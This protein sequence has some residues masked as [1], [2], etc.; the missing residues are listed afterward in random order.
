MDS[1]T[2]FLPTLSNLLDLLCVATVAVLCVGIG[3][4]VAPRTVPE[5]ALL[6]GWGLCCIVLTV[7]GCFSAVSLA[8]PT[9]VLAAAG[10]CGCWSLRDWRQDGLWRVAVSSA[11]IW[12][13]MLPV[14][15]SQVDTWLNLLPNAAYLVDH[16]MFPRSDRPPSYSFI[17]VAPYNTQFVAY[18]ASLLRGHLI[19]HGMGL[20]NILLQCA[21]SG[22]LARIVAGRGREIGWGAAA[23][24]L[25]LAMP[26]NPGFIPREFFS[27]Y[28]EAPIAVTAMTA[29]LLGAQ[30]TAEREDRG[31]RRDL[32]VALALIL[33]A[34]VNV[35][36]SAIGM[37]LGVLA[38]MAV[39]ALTEHER[40]HRLEQ[41]ILQA[42]PMLA[43]Y[44]IWRW[45][46][47]TSFAAGELKALP[48]AQW[49]IILIPRILEG[50]A[51]AISQKGVFFSAM[52]VV[53]AGAIFGRPRN[54]VT[55][56]AL[57]L[58][59]GTIL[60]DN[61]FI[62]FTYV[63]HFEPSWAVQAHSYFRYMAQLSLIVMLGLTL[64]A[65]PPAR[66]WFDSR[67]GRLRQALR[68]AAIT[69]ILAAPFAVIRYLRFDLEPPQP[70][71]SGMVAAIKPFL[72]SGEP[73][74]LVVTDDPDDIAGSYLRG[75]LLF[76]TPRADFPVVRTGS[77]GDAGTLAALRRDGIR[78]IL[79]ACSSQVSGIPGPPALAVLDA[80]ADGWRVAAALPYPSSWGKGHWAGLV[81]KASLCA[82][83]S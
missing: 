6:A 64:L 81:S 47:T 41:I 75:L 67:T 68:V 27:D 14:G 25:L 58:G 60:V 17:P 55:R 21:A 11:G 9:G 73:L 45:Y 46:A 37:A 52:A 57:G 79:V 19:G 71:L 66:R 3:R 50:V 32:G 34:M 48:L 51:Y 44:G 56:A 62:L 74:A 1:L 18:A 76:T 53:L 29:V 80:S 20:F 22:L 33:A 61:A 49:N 70:A 31:R 28:G 5:V 16:G 82:T 78:Q 10:L 83:P 65:E 4:L 8:I 13:V 36:Q 2:H 24:G 38:S 42:L 63:A 30:W 72:R 43:L 12:L 54:Q 35:K 15:P 77:L 39:A 40:R 26:L 7:W 23:L 69:L 59:A